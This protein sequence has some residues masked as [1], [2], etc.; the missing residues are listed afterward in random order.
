MDDI[1]DLTTSKITSDVALATTS[2]AMSTVAGQTSVGSNGDS[3]IINVYPS[4]G[5]DE[6]ALAQKIERKLIETQNR[7]RLAWG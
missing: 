3:F 7:R 4:S 6:E 5:M 1:V 2:K